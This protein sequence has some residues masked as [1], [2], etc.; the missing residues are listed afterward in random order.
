MHRFLVGLAIICAAG[1][2][3]AVQVVDDLGNLV[4]LPQ[5]AQRIVSLAPHITETLFAAGA[6]EQVVAV[7]SHSD[8]PEAAQRLPQVGTYTNVNIELLLSFKPDLVVAWQS[9]NGPRLINRLRE[10]GLPLYVTNPQTPEDIAGNLI[11]FGI[12]SGNSATARAV[13]AK[14]SAKLQ[15]LRRNYAGRRKVSTFYQV[16]NDPLVTVNG[17]HLIS[18]LI[19]LCGGHNV[20]A[21][22]P[23]LAPRI[24]PES[25]LVADPEAII[26]SGM[27]EGRPDWLDM[28]LTWPGLRAVNRRHLFYIPPD[29]VQRHSPRILEG[30]A[31]LCKQLEQVRRD[32]L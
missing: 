32:S 26:A 16:W 8:Y 30:A 2:C 17:N 25:V 12:I 27:G 19:T 9:G 1:L 21:E 7:V 29:I 23:T 24:N 15:T 18:R 11:N 10:L 5:P 22:L 13:G 28:W 6:G 20:F 14:Y 3:R 31:L 4:S